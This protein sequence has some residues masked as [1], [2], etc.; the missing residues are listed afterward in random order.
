MKISLEVQFLEGK[1]CLYD[2][3]G[4]HSGPKDVLLSWDVGGL[5]YPVQVV[6]VAEGRARRKK[7]EEQTGELTVG[8]SLIN[9]NISIA[10][11]V[12]ICYNICYKKKEQEKMKQTNK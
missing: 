6:Q 8:D 9:V 12:N 11:T 10:Q 1:V 2:A 5:G 4:F 3:C 7:Q